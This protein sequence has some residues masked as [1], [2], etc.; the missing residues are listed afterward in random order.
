M[1]ALRENDLAN[2]RP[3]M[4][5]LTTMLGGTVA[6][7]YSRCRSQRDLRIRH[8]Q[9]EQ[10]IV[11]MAKEN[12]DWGYDRIVGALANLGYRVCNQTVGNILQRHG[13]PPA[14]ERKRTITWSAFIRIHLALL[15][16]TDFFTVE[17]LTPR[18]L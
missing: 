3:P 8:G 16:A 12:H 17:V 13:L 10:L 11:R 18:G 4:P 5:S 6:A 14:P 1:A 9:V 7:V 15:A 2:R